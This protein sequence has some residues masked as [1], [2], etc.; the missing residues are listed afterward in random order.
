MQKTEDRITEKC[1][2]V[3]SLFLASGNRCPEMFVPY[4]TCVATCALRHD[5]VHDQRADALF[6]L[7][8]RWG[9]TTAHQQTVMGASTSCHL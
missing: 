1:H 8:I 4:V 2:D 6:G 9:I 3:S 7:M 5:L